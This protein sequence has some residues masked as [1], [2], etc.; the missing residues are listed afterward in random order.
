MEAVVVEAT[1]LDG[2][3]RTH[4][5]E[6]DDDAFIRLVIGDIL[7][8]TD[9]ATLLTPMIRAYLLSKRRGFTRAKEHH[10]WRGPVP[11]AAEPGTVRVRGAA[12]VSHGNPAMTERLRPLLNETIHIPGEGQVKWGAA[13]VTQLQARIKLYERTRSAMD[14]S[15][16][17]LNHAITEIRSHPG[18]T[19]LND[20]YA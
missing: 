7:T 9:P 15:I 12:A 1:T 3:V 14:R 13:T 2:L 6:P 4:A 17:D 10:A 16:A 8:E 19:C 5:G 18:A 20:I 11:A